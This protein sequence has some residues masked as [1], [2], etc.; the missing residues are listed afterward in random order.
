MYIGLHVMY[1]LFLSDFNET[2]IF[3]TE[4]RKI[5]KYQISWKSVQWEP[6][7]SMWTDG[8]TEMTKL[9]VAFRNFAKA[10]K[11][12]KKISCRIP[13]YRLN[14][15][16]YEYATTRKW[17]NRNCS[18]CSINPTLRNPKTHHASSQCLYI[19]LTLPTTVWSARRS[20]VLNLH[21]SV[22]MI[23]TYCRQ[24]NK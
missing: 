15:A 3:S 1:P 13:L 2:W 7:C 16:S 19:P 8:R 11:N 5:L 10:P 4:F 18:I 9:I 6:S 14:G 20:Y 17:I 22:L 21:F 23:F 24:A 12:E